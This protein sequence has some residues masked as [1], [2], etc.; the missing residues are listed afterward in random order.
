MNGT[1]HLAVGIALGVVYAQHAELDTITSI[2]VVG[3]TA[4]GALLPDIDHE[5]SKLGR[6]VWLISWSLRRLL[7]H[8]GLTHSIHAMTAVLAL[9]V[10][11]DSVYAIALALGVASHIILDM[12]TRRGVRLF[13]PFSG[14]WR[15][16]P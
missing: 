5:N 9:V 15:L 1:V 11:T 8:R 3:V 2:A 7:G 4:L 10:R 16:I 6:R 14:Y 12:L 13:Y